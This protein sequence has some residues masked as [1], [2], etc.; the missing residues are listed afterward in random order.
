MTLFNYQINNWDDWGRVFQSI[1]SFT[2]LVEYILKKENLP[3]IIIEHLTPG[4]NAVFKVGDYV[5]K[6]FAPA[7]SGIDQTPDLQT[8]L[9]A[10]KRANELGI[11][12]PRMA[13]HGFVEDAYRFAY[14]ITEY[15]EGVEFIEAVKTM[16]DDQKVSFGRKLRQ[17]TDKMNTPCESFNN[18]DVIN[19]KGR[20]RRWDKYPDSFKA[21]RLNYIKT[22][23][24]GEKV[25]CHGDLCGDNIIVTPQDVV[26]IIDF[27]DA[28]L[29][30]RAYEH[31]LIAFEF[32]FD[33][34]LIKGYFGDYSIEEFIEMC[35]SGILIHDFGGDILKEHVCRPDELQGLEDLRDIL[36][37]KITEKITSKCGC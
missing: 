10:T 12:A 3:P 1:P 29:A 13:A 21:E 32:K 18:I 6:I 24:F 25:F 31:V 9:F 15:I 37:A 28:V 36:R 20:Y 19:D 2:P 8:E 5:V 16:T 30:P 35:Y 4:T 23:D 33:P 11:S 14:M 22:H 26:Y 17:I 34:A 7:E 27:A